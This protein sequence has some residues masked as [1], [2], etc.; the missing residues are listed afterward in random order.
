MGRRRIYQTDEERLEARRTR[1]R[2]YVRA[3]RA[4]Q[5]QSALTLSSQA[6]PGEPATPWILQD[7]AIVNISEVNSTLAKSSV[8]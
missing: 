5:R 2:N 4:R 3:H 8:I 6:D 1:T 7:S